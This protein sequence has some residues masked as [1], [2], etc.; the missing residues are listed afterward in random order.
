MAKL[1]MTQW[2]LIAV[3]SVI[4]Y[5]LGGSRYAIS[6][7]LGGACYA[8][9]TLLS[10]LFLKFLKPYPALAGAAF[11]GSE[12]LKILLSLILLV[13]SFFVYPNV[14]FLSFFVGLLVVSH[15]VFLFFLKVY[16]YGSK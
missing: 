13:G 15:L 10:V 8:V 9:P 1:A 12:S 6:L 2:I 3:L 16:R 11:I 14:H 7:I 4:A 5:V